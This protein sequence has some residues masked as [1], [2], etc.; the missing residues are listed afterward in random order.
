MRDT[1]LQEWALT[2]EIIGG[3]AIVITLIFVG[4]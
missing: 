3:I 1:K 2:A 4:V